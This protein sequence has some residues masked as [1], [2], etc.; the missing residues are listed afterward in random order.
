MGSLSRQKG[1]RAE[2]QAATALERAIGCEARRSVQYCGANADADLSTTLDG[3]HFEVKARKS[4]AC[5]RFYA[6]AEADAATDDIP[7]VLLRENGD[8]R[9]FALVDLD[10]IRAL[11]QKILDI[12]A[13]H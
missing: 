6:Q 12:G 3:V 2:R 5:L 1:K 10:H 9:V 11:A 4:H 8:V 13:K 7:V